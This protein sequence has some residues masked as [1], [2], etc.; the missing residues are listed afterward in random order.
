MQ[1]ET[2]Q[3][4]LE[5]AGA[6]F[7][8]RGYR[9]TTV[10]E[11]CR[12]AGVNVAAINYHFGGKEHLYLEV[13]RYCHRRARDR[14]PPDLGVGRWA[15]PEQRLRAFIHSFLL[16]LLQDGPGAWHGRLISRELIEPTGALDALVAER[17]RPLADELFG[18]LRPL[19]GAPATRETLRLCAASVVSQCLFYHH[20]RSVISRLF[21][22]QHFGPRD[23]RRLA[24]H[25]AD[26]SLAALPQ[27][28]R[29]EAR[30]RGPRGVRRQTRDPE[31]PAGGRKPR[32]T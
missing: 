26:F 4:L 32:R 21:P 1:A 24:E 23:I 3:V 9:A 8:E 12:R 16:R 11:V 10:R 27:L 15:A 17:F 6:V 25:I 28:A 7:A 2:Q 14:Y 20:C 18:I 30:R 13:L 19:L 31:S 29:A 22:Q 5:T